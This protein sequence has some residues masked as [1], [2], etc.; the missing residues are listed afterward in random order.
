MFAYLK[1]VASGSDDATCHRV[2]MMAA[3][4]AFIIALLV[5]SIAAA[6]GVK[7]LAT[8]LGVV[9]APLGTMV[10]AAYWKAKDK[11]AT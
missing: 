1:L 2:C 9:A 3:T 5:L 7:D 6:C 8:A 11:E 10:G 4:A